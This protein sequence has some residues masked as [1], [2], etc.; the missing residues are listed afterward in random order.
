MPRQRLTPAQTETVVAYLVRNQQ[1]IETRE[2]G[3]TEVA[4]ECSASVGYG[5]RPDLVTDKCKTH[6]IG[7][8]NKSP[9]VQ[10]RSNYAALEARLARLETGL[11]LKPAEV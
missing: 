7:L 9:V 8:I 10:Q 6:G 3:A 1:D 11:G 5:V 2:L 4:K